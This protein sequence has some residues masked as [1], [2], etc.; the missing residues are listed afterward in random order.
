[1]TPWLWSSEMQRI[2]LE[3]IA[4]M[5]W[6]P[7]CVLQ[8]L[9]C[10]L[11]PELVSSL[12]LCSQRNNLTIIHYWSIVNPLSTNDQGARDVPA[13]V[14]QLSALSR[15]SRPYPLSLCTLGPWH[16]VIPSSSCPVHCAS[17]REL[18]SIVSWWTADTSLCRS[19]NGT[20][21][22]VSGQAPNTSSKCYWYWIKC[23]FI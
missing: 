7:T 15:L 8:P 16:A 4:S 2:E 1:M 22:I 19:L 21:A 10:S 9:L 13:K 6:P 23:R 11:L 5:L 14:R 20:W 3:R 17:H 18:G 12:R